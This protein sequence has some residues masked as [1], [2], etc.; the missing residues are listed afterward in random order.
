M[1]SMV[2]LPAV[3][4]LVVVG[5]E[6]VDQEHCCRTLLADED[7]V[8]EGLQGDAHMYALLALAG[9]FT[10]VGMLFAFAQTKRKL[11]GDHETP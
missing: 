2:L 7:A 10:T 11:G 8:G 1:A 3:L 5:F 6:S 4:V 9:L